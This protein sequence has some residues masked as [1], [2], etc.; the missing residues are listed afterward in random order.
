MRHRSLFSIVTVLAVA[1]ATPAAAAAGAG[2]PDPTFGGKRG[3]AV[4][5]FPVSAFPYDMVQRPD[6]RLV[7]AGVSHGRLAVARF[8]SDGALDP[9]FGRGGRIRYATPTRLRGPNGVRVALD[10][11]GRILVVAT[12][13]GLERI[14][15]A[16]L[17]P[18]GAL[19]TSFGA[20]GFAE[21]VVAP[22]DTIWA[23]AIAARPDGGVVVLGDDPFGPDTISLWALTGSGAPDTAFDGDGLAR[24][25][26]PA[27]LESQFQGRDLSVDD[28]D[29]V[30]VLAAGLYRNPS[31][32]RLVSRPVL[33]RLT[34]SAALDPTFGVDGIATTSRPYGGFEPSRMQIDG[35]HI[36]VAG[37][38]YRFD[39]GWG[40]AVVRL[41][42]DGSVD[43]SF[44]DHGAVSYPSSD[45]LTPTDLAVAPD[46]ALVMSLSTQLGVTVLRLTPEGALDTSFSGDGY[47]SR[48]GVSFDQAA[49]AVQGSGDVVSLGWK[50]VGGH[51]QFALIRFFG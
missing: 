33:L 46:G 36:V 24:F 9:A 22:G 28:Q 6:G 39:A 47:A 40:A 38:P 23:D 25:Q 10:A 29:R 44:G 49:V 34:S 51:R 18:T 7:V 14:E 3:I 35:D 21:L 43:G 31:S 48:T 41:S 15:V 13:A 1:I 2:S 26:A 8:T 32:L 45:Y 19:D 30:T 17:R 12:A 37:T 4:S 5:D 50:A 27:P 16:R 42:V 11:K 20:G